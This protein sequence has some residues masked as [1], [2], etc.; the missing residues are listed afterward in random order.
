MDEA[1]NFS[2]FFLPAGIGY[3]S[4]LYMFSMCFPRFGSPK[5][6]EFGRNISTQIEGI[7]CRPDRTIPVSVHPEVKVDGIIP[8]YFQFQFIGS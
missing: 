2:N 3:C 8:S 7:P 5:C 1:E 6:H 4:C